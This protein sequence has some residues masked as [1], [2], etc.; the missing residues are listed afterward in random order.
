MISYR[1]L[2]ETM[3]NRGIT[4]YKLEQM[5]FSRGTYY[6]IK[7]GNSISTHT[8]NKLCKFL[9]CEVSDII[10]YVDEDEIAKR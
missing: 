9:R 1:P 5:G 3:K 8:I 2:Y 7:Q 6:S 10:E 4:T